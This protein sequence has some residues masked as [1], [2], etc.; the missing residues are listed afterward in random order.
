VFSELDDA[1]AAALVA[2]LPGGQAVL[3]TAAHLPSG[4]SPDAVVRVAG[5]RI[6]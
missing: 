5:G 4:A 1:R 6:S 2:H 3:T